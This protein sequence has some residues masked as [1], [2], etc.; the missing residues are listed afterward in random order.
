MFVS[1][2]KELDEIGLY[3]EIEAMGMYFGPLNQTEKITKFSQPVILEPWEDLLVD[4]PSKRKEMRSH[5]V[6]IIKQ[7]NKGVLEM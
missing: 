4:I 2:S 6:N 1:G 7:Q 5:F 3:K